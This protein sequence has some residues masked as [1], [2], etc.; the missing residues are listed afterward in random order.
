MAVAFDAAADRL[1]HS[2]AY[3]QTSAG[4][5]I[6]AWARLDV[7]QNNWSTFV[8]IIGPGTLV[9]FSTLQDGTRGPAYYTPVTSVEYTTSDLS[10]P[11]T[12]VWV[13]VA[14]TR[15]TT[16]ITVYRKPSGTG[17]TENATASMASTDV[18]GTGSG[19]CLGGRDAS[20]ATEWLNGALAYV[21][22]WSAALSQA[23]IEAEWASTTPVR[24]SGLHSNWP[25]ATS[26][27]LTDTVG[28]KTLAVQSGG[29]LTTTTGPTLASASEQP[30]LFRR[31]P[32]RGLILR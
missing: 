17:S 3:P 30:F 8:R 24:S 23:E 2:G 11:T 6:T 16:A 22:V 26:S 21:R 15:S 29:S 10:S 25:L 12:G 1:T 7:D 20:D 31:R 14:C 13:P 18:T 5:T 28:S 27:D 9:T 4:L 19:I 32:A